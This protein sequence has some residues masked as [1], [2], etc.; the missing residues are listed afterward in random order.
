L[1]DR[2]VD[3]H[4]EALGRLLGTLQVAGL[5]DSTAVIVTGDVATPEA[6]PVPFLDADGLDEA[7]LG[8]PL[9]V[10]WP[11]AMRLSG[12]H[13]IVASSSSDLAR[14]TMGALGLASPVSFGGVDLATVAMASHRQRAVFAARDERESARWGPFVLLTFRRRE[15][16]MCDLSLDPTCTTDVRATAPIALAALRKALREERAVDGSTSLPRELATIDER[17]TS[18]L[19]RWGWARDEREEEP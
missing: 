5:G 11:R 4:D 18:A 14:T 9:V 6:L 10:R 17:T 8:V 12:R 13:S 7:L 15:V 16:R 2:A 1:Y 3:A 19:V